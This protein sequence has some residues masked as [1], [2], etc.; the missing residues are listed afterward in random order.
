Q[1][2]KQWRLV[3]AAVRT[4]EFAGYVKQRAA[5]LAD[6]SD[7]P[8][9][10][11]GVALT[12]LVRR[13]DESG[14]HYQYVDVQFNREG[15]LATI[16]VRAP[17]AATAQSAEQATTLGAAWWPLQMARELDDAVL[18]LRTNE[19]EL[20]LWILKTTGN[21]DAVLAI[22]AFIVENRDH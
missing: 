10:A 12:P 4:Q 19:L 18:S 17:E 5:A 2:A 3:D 6:A 13:A 8:R 9:D 15:R 14:L 7:R 11:Q 22:D 16:T 21:P 20:G 1:R